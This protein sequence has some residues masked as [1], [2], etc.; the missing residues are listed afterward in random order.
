MV[1]RLV[2]AQESL[3]EDFTTKKLAIRAELPNGDISSPVLYI[4]TAAA[5]TVYRRIDR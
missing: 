1:D 3:Q 4:S 2:L 5:V